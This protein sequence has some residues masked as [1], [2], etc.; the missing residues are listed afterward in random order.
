M[1]TRNVVLLVLLGVALFLFVPG[2]VIVAVVVPKFAAS[3]MAV[4]EM[5]AVREIR[6]IH[7][8]QVQYYSMY[9]KYAATLAELGPPASGT[10]GPQAADLISKSLALG[11]KD[12][13]VFTLAATPKGYAIN[14][15]PKVYNT[16]GRRTFYSDD[17]LTIH[18]NVSQ[19]P[20]NASSLELK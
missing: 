10:A 1:K 19:E 20:A 8:A 3:R 2:L 6:A 7:S 15:N 16:T 12:G 9:G 17:T 18:Q 13:Y 11:E 4:S 14:A 5:G